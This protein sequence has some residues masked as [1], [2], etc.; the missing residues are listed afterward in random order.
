MTAMMQ[1][2]MTQPD[3]DAQVESRRSSILDVVLR[4]WAMLGFICAAAIIVMLAFGVLGMWGLYLGFV[5]FI[6]APAAFFVLARQGGP[7]R[8][9]PLLLPFAC[10][11]A[12]AVGLLMSGWTLMKVVRH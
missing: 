10:M 1:P 3:V 6:G 4:T 12:G 7:V 2:D 11:M 8:T 5:A 9:I